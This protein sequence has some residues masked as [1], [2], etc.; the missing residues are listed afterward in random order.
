[1]VHV[2]TNKSF[3]FFLLPTELVYL[4]FFSFDFLVNLCLL[5]IN[6][7]NSGVDQFYKR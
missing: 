4:V 3:F 2:A 1:M 6:M 5:Q 7:M